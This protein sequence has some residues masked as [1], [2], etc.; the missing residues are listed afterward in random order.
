MCSPIEI[1]DDL[2]LELNDDSSL[3]LEYEIAE[4]FKSSA[5]IESTALL[6]VDENVAM[7]SYKTRQ[8]HA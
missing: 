6:D 1:A 7:S 3:I 4:E 2:S 5:I 8:L